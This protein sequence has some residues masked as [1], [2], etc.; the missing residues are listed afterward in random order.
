[1]RRLAHSLLLVLLLGC[2]SVPATAVPTVSIL[3][4]LRLS[5]PAL[6][7]LSA[8]LQPARELPLELPQECG[9]RGLFPAPRGAFL[10]LE[11]N[12]SFG[13]TVLFLDTQS[14]A[15]T[16]AYTEADSHFLAWTRDGGAVYLKVDTL[17]NARILRV[18]TSGRGV[19][20]PVSE[21]TYDLAPQPEGDDFTF[22]FSRGLGLG[23]ELWLA[24]RD[25]NTVQLLLADRNNY[26][27]FARWSPDG[28]RLAFIKIPDSATPFPMGELWVMG[29]D[30]SRAR[31]L[32]AADAGHGF[33]PAWSPDGKRIAYV[34]RENLQDPRADQFDEALV[35]NIY[36]VEVESGTTTPVTR[37]EKARVEAPVWSAD[38]ESL[39]FTVLMDDKI[40]VQQVNLASGAIGPVTNESVCCP[41]WMQK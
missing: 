11:L 33:A 36:I 24:G 31:R 2:S 37:F 28:G 5:P 9:F 41:A 39:A 18:D 10:A 1:M 23:S 27:S 19:F 22:T 26:L 16:Q 32:A 4:V 6:I 34:G 40:S 29:A 3:Y 13:Q 20:V 17:G 14:G 30:G 35:S 21:L 7:Q 38:G 15:L 12:C 25:A 8:D